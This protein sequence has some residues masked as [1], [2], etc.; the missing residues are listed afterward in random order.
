MGGPLVHLGD[1][2]TEAAAVRVLGKD[3]L[4]DLPAQ[5]AATELRQE[6]DLLNEDAGPAHLR[7][8]TQG[9]IQIARQPAFLEDQGAPEQGLIPGSSQKGPLH[10]LPGD[11]VVYR[12]GPV[13][14][15]HHGQDGVPV[16][17]CHIAKGQHS[18]PPLFHCLLL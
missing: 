5:A 7:G 14:G 11:R 2:Q 12:V 9:D 1:L 3:P 6:I 18:D 8:V 17:Q 13:E 10:D 16:V 4:Q 15:I